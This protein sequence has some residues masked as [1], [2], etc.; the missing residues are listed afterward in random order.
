MRC[1]LQ[2]L[3][4]GLEHAGERFNRRLM[5][6]A[7]G[8]AGANLAVND[9]PRLAGW[10]RTRDWRVARWPPSGAAAAERDASAAGTD[11]DA[12]RVVWDAAR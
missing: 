11:A 7:P 2:R 8:T 4:R 3:A 1:R 10:P 6:G 9:Q 5:V 12:A